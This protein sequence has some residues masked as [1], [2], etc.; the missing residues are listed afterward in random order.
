METQAP[1]LKA[2]STQQLESL[3]STGT[4]APQRV[5]VATELGLRYQD[6]NW[7]RAMEICTEAIPIART[8]EDTQPLCRLLNNAGNT[9][10]KLQQYVNS[11]NYYLEAMELNEKAGRPALQATNLGNLGVIYYEFGDY[12][13]AI[14]CF[15]QSIDVSIK[16]GNHRSAAHN[17][18]NIASIYLELE[19]AEKAEEFL[20]RQ[21]EE[22][23]K[24]G[25]VDTTS[26]GVTH[27]ANVYILKREYDKAIELLTT[28]INKARNSNPPQ[29]ISPYTSVLGYVYSLTGQWEEA[30]K[31]CEETLQAALKNKND[32][33][34]VIK[35]VHLAELYFKPEAPF[36]NYELAEDYL[37][38]A[39]EIAARKGLKR[40]LYDIHTKLSDIYRNT[41][42]WQQSAEH[43]RKFY[44]LERE[45]RKEEMDKK[46]MSFEMQRKLDL[47]EREQE[48]TIGILYNV[49]PRQVADRIKNGEEKIIERFENA[50][51]M[52]ADIVDFTV[53]SEGQDVVNVAN[54]LN[55][56]FHLF[57]ELALELGVEKIK[58]IGDA[59]MCVAGLP[60]PCDDHAERIAQMAL[61][62]NARID[63]SFPN[64]ELRLRIG[65]H[66]G[67]VI[68]GV[69]G[70]RKYAYDLWGNTVN[71][72]SRMESHGQPQKIQV[73]EEV[74]HHL[75]DKFHFT[76]RG[77]IEVK[78]KGRMRVYFLEGQK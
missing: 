11:M 28:A 18:N 25:E 64:G 6:S 35:Y 66:T 5:A 38:K 72:A 24:A 58:T 52:F 15:L 14:N 36:F 74:A 55:T 2:L 34:A 76:E 70:K 49:L 7:Q 54:R 16:M 53:W 9:A 29:E 12:T 22:L 67:E 41:G 4:D 77:E 73:T 8:F 10:H 19:N 43:F 45:V 33:Q 20:Q 17:L 63:E 60:E 78:G 59:Y 62:M 69:L 48:V 51:V 1:D 50:T 56:I 61:A 47:K 57:D 26:I 44:E 71:T 46:M 68:A 39:M 32:K 31:Y 21:N 65:I 30:K 23:Q 40:Q 37:V 75:K 27:Y 42:R 13:E 3:F